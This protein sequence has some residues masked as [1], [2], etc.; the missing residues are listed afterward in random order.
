MFA[1]IGTTLF[2]YTFLPLV[3][4]LQGCITVTPLFC[5]SMYGVFHVPLGIAGF[6]VVSHLVG[7]HNVRVFLLIFIVLVGSGTLL[8]GPLSPRE[9]HAQPV[10]VFNVPQ[11]YYPFT[12]WV[13][14]PFNVSY[15][16]AIVGDEFYVFE[17][18]FFWPYHP[19]TIPSTC[20]A[21]IPSNDWELV[22]VYV[23]TATQQVTGVAYRFH[24]GWTFIDPTYP[25]G[26]IAV[27]PANIATINATRP[28]VTFISRY[29]VPVNDYPSGARYTADVKTGL[30][31]F[32]GGFTYQQQ[33]Y[34]YTQTPQV[35]PN[36]QPIDPGFFRG[37]NWYNIEYLTIGGFVVTISA[38]VIFA[39]ERKKLAGFN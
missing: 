10:P 12:Y 7:K 33:D 30:L 1:S 13:D 3:G 21:P 22:Y 39:F 17:W 34:N 31:E 15:T 19:V 4:G 36:A 2:I 27:T 32:Q 38:G 5:F 35:P 37:L 29:H 8:I 26:V 6:F 23:S 16:T 20:A 14:K 28:V 25:G 9:V 24:C 11:D 18:A